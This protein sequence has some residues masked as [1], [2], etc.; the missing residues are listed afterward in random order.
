MRNLRTNR[1]AVAVV[2]VLSSFASL[3][4]YSV[5]ASGD[6]P[7]KLNDSISGEIHAIG[8]ALG[9]PY[10][11]EWYDEDMPPTS[12]YI[13]RQGIN[14]NINATKYICTSMADTNCA[15]AATSMLAASSWLTPCASEAD[16]GCIEELK[17]STNGSPTTAL[18]FSAY[19]TSIDPDIPEDLTYGIPKGATASIWTAT[20]G[21]TYL[22]QAKTSLTWNVVPPATKWKISTN[23]FILNIHR[24]IMQPTNTYVGD[25][26]PMHVAL[27]TPPG[28]TTPLITTSGSR[29]VQTLDKCALPVR[30]RPSTRI[31]SKVRLPDSFSGWMTGRLENGIVST[32]QLSNQRIRYSVEA[33][34]SNTYIAGGASLISQTPISYF[35]GSAPT[36][37]WVGHQWPESLT[38]YKAHAATFGEKALYTRESWYL[39][40]NNYSMSSMTAPASSRNCFASS[41][42]MVG[43]MTT[44]ASAFN[45][46]VPSWDS[47]TGELT[48]EVASPHFD[49]NGAVATGTYSLSLPPDAVKCL[50]GDTALPSTVDV[51]VIEAGQVQQS[52][53]VTV[54]QDANWI[55]FFA[56]GFHFSNP[57]LKVRLGIAPK[58]LTVPQVL[59]SPIAPVPTYISSKVG[60]K[61]S[62]SSIASF[63]KIARPKGSTTSLLVASSSRKYC[64]VVGTSVQALKKGTCTITV[65]V[66]VPKKKTISKSVK[67]KIG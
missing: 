13:S 3:R 57:T 2:V 55:R 7:I 23:A 4:P 35:G 58:A 11:G 19:L 66:K 47:K 51:D 36:Q 8:A 43:L 20:N 10:W 31:S 52:Q 12:S 54:T 44:N 64:K 9:G 16:L 15:E 37:S 67:I 32:T 40:S 42:G 30:F 17:I 28:G 39:Q 53:K 65:S 18:N 34:P 29:C 49:E 56:S 62:V 21:D 33:D 61:T 59:A 1:L 63:A 14:S 50:Y 45:N 24:V 25:K 60:R 26:S 6:E 48:Y 5:G 38:A 27:V 46:S 41:S 22:I